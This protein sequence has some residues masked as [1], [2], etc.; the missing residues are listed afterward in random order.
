MPFRYAFVRP[1]LLVLAVL[2]G[3][4]LIPLAAG[5]AA[6]PQPVQGDVAPGYVLV[7]LD[8]AV[9]V[10]LPPG[11]ELVFGSWYKVPVSA[12]E[13]PAAAARRWAAVPGIIAAQPDTIIQ[14]DRE[15]ETGFVA[16]GREAATDDGA[17]SLSAAMVPNDP[18]Y[19]R[20]WNFPMIQAEQAW[21]IATGSGVKV[22]VVDSGV[23][24]GDDLACATFV[25]DYN[26]ITN[27]AGPGAANDEY[28]HGTHVAG[29]IAQCT[30]NG[31]GVTGLAP[32]VQLMPIRVLDAS[33]SGLFANVA[34]GVDWA[35]SHG[36]QVINLSLGKSCGALT[37]PSCA[38]SLLNDA[39]TA[40]VAADIV[41]VAAAGNFN[42]GTMMYP[43][44][45]P[46]V[47]A[48]TAVDPNLT[49]APYAHQ[50]VA[51]DLAAPGG[52]T[53]IDLGGI[54]NGGGILQQS[55]DGSNWNAYVYKHGTSMAAAHVSGAAAL[56]RSY[57]PGATRL[58][59]QDAL[60][61]SAQDLG[62]QGPDTTFGHGLIQIAAA[63]AQV[64]AAGA[65]STPTP[66]PTI[67]PMVTLTPTP[68]V[69]PTLTP[70]IPIVH[71]WLPLVWQEG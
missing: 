1:L 67:T 60:Q 54:K 7:K 27:Q 38:D 50:G 36:A 63:L 21:E 10:A 5:R 49:K 62:T 26:A 55:K 20:Q 24:R 3:L 15:E 22:A 32:G 12:G 4:S 52:N 70:T 33:G 14:V 39:I 51:L 47:I 46:D 13:E 53:Q 64:Q 71:L 23:R 65:T 69:T 6:P 43:A 37:W 44:N 61:N 58:Q 57:V 41:I 11:S 42:Q 59:V 40:A 66:T 68:T 35:R 8:P 25:D 48:V 45:H 29:T 34:K 17:A 19:E 28:G 18:L 30:N 9:Q 16:S 31:I 56:L 2:A